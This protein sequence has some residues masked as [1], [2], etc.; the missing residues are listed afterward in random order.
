MLF[1]TESPAEKRAGLRK[2]LDGGGLLRFAGAYSPLVAMLIERIGFDGVYVGSSTLSNDLGLPDI[3]LVTQTEAVERSGAIARVTALPTLVDVDTGY[4]E[5]VN[6]ARTVR[7]LEDCGLAACHL[8]DQVN[9]K[10]CGHLDNKAVIDADVMVE[11]VR[12]A[13]A[14]RRDPNFLV[15][16]R[17]DA[18]AV[19]GFDA[20]V[21][22]ARAYADAGADMIFPEAMVDEDGFARF[23]AAVDAP[24]I[25]NMTEF[26]KSPLLH[27]DRLAS[28]GYQIVI[29][30]ATAQRLA[31]KA[32]E[33]GLRQVLEDGTQQDLLPAMQTRAELYDLIRYD[34][35]A[36]FDRGVAGA[37]VDGTPPP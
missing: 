12:A 31:M 24:L 8:E 9:P 25:A 29:Y 10:R 11:R 20:A 17:T 21:A 2:A 15:V 34:D 6:A 7:E 3:G 30:P 18:G 22:R 35:Y 16:A 26:G 27:A 13:V 28:L 33:Q 32:V 23:R 37:L 5:A 36:G 14:A 19:E 1:P 4:G